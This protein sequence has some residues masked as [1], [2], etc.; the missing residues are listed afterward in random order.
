[1]GENAPAV[2]APATSATRDATETFI[3]IQYEGRSDTFMC[4]LKQPSTTMER[5]R[6]STDADVEWADGQ[7]QQQGRMGRRWP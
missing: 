6:E 3:A 7:Q 2:L 5:F 4:F 1:M